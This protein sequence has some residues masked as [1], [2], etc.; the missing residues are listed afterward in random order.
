MG[1]VSERMREESEWDTEEGGGVGW[2]SEGGGEKREEREDIGRKGCRG[3]RG[4]EVKER[5]SD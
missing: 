1:E 4:R 2:E 5:R 3:R